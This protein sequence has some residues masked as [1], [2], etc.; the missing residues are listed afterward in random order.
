MPSSESSAGSTG[1]TDKTKPEI[2]SLQDV[3]RSLVGKVATVSNPE[4]MES[5][6]LGF[7]IKPGFHRAKI[8]SVHDDIITVATEAT[9]G[10]PKGEK[11]PVKQFIPFQWIKRVCIMKG[12]LHL[13]L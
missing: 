9:K 12:E 4:S 11:L 10:G 7:Q 1:E 5:I 8:L 6:P 3:L 13:H 2:H